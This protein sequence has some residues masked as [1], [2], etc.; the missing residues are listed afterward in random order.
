MLTAYR[1]L[2]Y[3]LLPVASFIGIGV[4]ML[5]MGAFSNP[6][7]LLS[8]FVAGGVVLYSFSSFQ[9]L[10][11]GINR[12]HKLKPGRKDFIKVNAYV[13]LFFGVMNLFQS[14]TLIADSKI[15]NEVLGQVEKGFPQEMPFKKEQLYEIVRGM[16]YFLLIY[17]IA[18]VIH[19]Q[20]TF[21]LLRKF[22]TV[23]QREEQ[24]G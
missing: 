16:L 15:L 2:S 3:L 9:F 10:T 23:F 8:V 7:I 22:A 5:L 20:L 11:K 19:V 1:I 24:G 4:L 6:A 18:L 12:S 13:A 14:V 17:A 21:R